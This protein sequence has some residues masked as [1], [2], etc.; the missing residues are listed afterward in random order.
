[1]YGKTVTIFNYYESATTGET[2]WYPH[3]LSGVD[4]N[5]DKGAVL[6]KYGQDSSDTAQLHIPFTV[7]GIKKNI[8]VNGSKPTESGI[9][10]NLAELKDANGL[11]IFDCQND[12]IY[13]EYKSDALALEYLPPKKWKQQTNDFLEKTL[14]FSTEDFFWE[15]QWDQGKV[16]DSDY[17]KGFYQYMNSNKDNVFRITSIGGPYT[18]IPHFE[19]LAK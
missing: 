9:I 12:E 8:V 18:L 15:G 7:N 13:A 19:I 6:Q 11:F 14:T 4:L 3:V 5:T 16:L 17:K 10:H 2:Y 1:M